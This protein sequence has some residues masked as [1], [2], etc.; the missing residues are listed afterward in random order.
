MSVITYTLDKCSKCMK[1]VQVCPTNAIKMVDGRAYISKEKCINCARC[2]Q[3]CNY[4]GMTAKGSTIVDINSYEYTVVLV[5][6]AMICHFNNI[7]QVSGLYHA[8]EKLGFDEVINLSE[9]EAKLYNKACADNSSEVRISAFCPLVNNLIKLQ[10]PIL[11]DKL[12][13]FDYP[14][15]VMAK[16]IRRKYENKNVGIFNLCECAAKLAL[17][18][19]PYQNM[20]YE[21]D[22]ALSIVDIFPLI[23]DDLDYREKKDIQLDIR[24]LELTNS[25]TIEHSEKVFTLEGFHGV[26]NVLEMAEFGLLEDY[27]LLRLYPCHGG[28]LAGFL[29]WGNG[30]LAKNNIYKL[31]NSSLD[32]LDLSD[33]ILINKRISQLDKD[34]RT[35][36]EKLAYFDKVNKQLERLPG[37]DCT[38]CGLATCRL[39][40]E[41]IVNGKRKL[42]DC[43]ILER[44]DNDES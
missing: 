4:Q 29:M 19:Y 21:V 33:D 5:P 7:D 12:L 30:Y 1:C 34:K 14:S 9:V 37:Y 20:E 41:E 27:K 13:P 26:T 31:T 44:R 16:I 40:A 17:A 32:N 22:H 28:C 39:M 43:K 11:N 8:L 25:Y 42:S 15:E 6:S 23:K 18:K 36:R 38:A 35:I 10:F 3:V 2:I 24:G